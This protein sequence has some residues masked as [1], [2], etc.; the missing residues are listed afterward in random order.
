MILHRLFSL[1]LLLLLGLSAHGHAVAPS[2]QTATLSTDTVH[3]KV[4]ASHHTITPGQAFK[5]AW[6]V[7]LDANWHIYW[8][9]PGDSGIAP[10]LSITDDRFAIGSTSWPTPKVISIPP[11]TN[12]GY[13]NEV[14]FLT[15]VKAPE[16]LKAGNF[17]LPLK[18]DYL[19]CHEVCLPGTIST[20]LPLLVGAA[21]VANPAYATLE[22]TAK[23]KEPKQLETTATTAQRKSDSYTLRLNANAM[24][25]APTRF[26][27]LMEGW[28]ND[29]AP[30][31]VERDGGFYTITLQADPHGSIVPER[32]GGLIL[33]TNGQSYRIAP[34]LEVSTG[35]G[36]LEL[37]NESLALAL[38]FALLAGLILNLMPCVLPVLSL[39][40]FGLVQAPNARSR[41]NHALVYAGGVVAS[42]WA[43]A[44]IIAILQGGGTALGWGFHL[45]N[46]A[47]VGILVTLML[48]LGLNFLG[49]FEWGRTF[50]RLGLTTKPGGKESHAQAF[51][52][53]LLAVIV[54]T[55]CTVPFMG[56]AMAY[57]LSQS[58][59]ASMLVFTMLGV[60]M[61]LPIVLVAA[62]P[63][64]SKRLPRPGEWM[65]ILRKLLAWP[66]FGTGL[67]LAWV[68]G[69][70]AGIGAMAFLLMAQLVLAFLLWVYGLKPGSLTGVLVLF[71]LALGSLMVAQ[72]TQPSNHPTA[73]EPWSTTVQEQARTKQPVFVDFT[74]DWCLTCKVTEATVLNTA[75]VQELFARHNVKLLMGDWTRQDPAITTELAR[76]G[77][78][79]VP[80]YL[81]YKPGNEEPIILPQLLSHGILEK[82]LG[83][84]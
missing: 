84:E 35:N 3:N 57:A 15:E 56:G 28:L 40:V 68:F 4:V 45:Q 21:P 5:L 47:F 17:N 26:I 2:G 71:W 58:L 46:P 34:A 42:F 19:Y 33:A 23:A 12:Y 39:K 27:P 1:C 64:L 74:A 54:A 14:V 31:K 51:L 59:P 65:I 24:D 25:D 10:Q 49:V 8:R 82:A 44:V 43:F 50:T 38:V 78:R 72:T 53:G 41:L 30:Q 7:K 55:P 18:L 16:K 48:V 6:H 60:G 77:R 63:A 20:T 62:V 81:L 52:T 36:R 75:P 69:Q 32:L 13:E 70:Q 29:S 73:W 37:G 79:G 66:L 76:H 61:A 67:W 83:E 22:S 80:L 9:N 11:I